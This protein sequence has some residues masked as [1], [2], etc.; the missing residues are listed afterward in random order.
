[1]AKN[2]PKGKMK[3]LSGPHRLG[4]AWQVPGYATGVFVHEAPSGEVARAVVHSVRNG[5][6]K[7]KAAPHLHR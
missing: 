5:G 4:P 2:Q 6:V 1:M 7:A 3:D